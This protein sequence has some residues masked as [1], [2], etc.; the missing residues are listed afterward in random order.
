MHTIVSGAHINYYVPLAVELYLILTANRSTDDI[1][2]VIKVNGIS[3]ACKQWGTCNQ[4][5]IQHSN[6]MVLCS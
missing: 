6:L 2:L 3:L 1:S 5:F 4:I